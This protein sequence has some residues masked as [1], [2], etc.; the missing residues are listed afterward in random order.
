MLLLPAQS[1]RQATRVTRQV[2][3]PIAGQLISHLV[4]VGDAVA[5]DTEV[6]VIEAMKMHI[7]VA[8]EQT[9]RV[10]KWLVGEM[11]VVAEGDA[12]LELEPEP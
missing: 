6:G 9:G 4:R 8:A 3:S 1:T 10:A 7:P 12:L 5:T 11:S 2:T